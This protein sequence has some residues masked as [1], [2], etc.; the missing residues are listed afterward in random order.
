MAPGSVLAMDATKTSPTKEQLAT[1]VK[2]GL[3]VDD[4][5]RTPRRASMHDVERDNELPED[6]TYAGIM[7]AER[8]KQDK[9]CVVS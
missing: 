3:P 8:A 4:S 7:K 1:G 2:L 6:E 5:G 9:D